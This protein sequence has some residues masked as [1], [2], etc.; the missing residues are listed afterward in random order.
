[1]FGVARAIRKS[2]QIINETSALQRLI[3]G[4]KTCEAAPRKA[5]QLGDRRVN[6]TCAGLSVVTDAVDDI[7][8]HFGVLGDGQHVVTRAGD[9]VPHQENAV[10]LTL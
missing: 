3:S 1:M 10:S 2:E 5:A 4:G 8:G 7:M 9:R 6:V